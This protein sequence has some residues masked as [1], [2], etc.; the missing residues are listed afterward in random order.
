MNRN[1]ASCKLPL[2]G[3]DKMILAFPSKNSANVDNAESVGDIDIE[4]NIGNVVLAVVLM[5]VSLSI[6][7]NP[8][9]APTNTG[10]VK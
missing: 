5:I 7:D 9:S 8:R 1:L 3:F 10:I 4:A 2:T 6:E